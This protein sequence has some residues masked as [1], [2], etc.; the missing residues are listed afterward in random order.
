MAYTVYC[1]TNKINGKK[2]VGLTKLP[3][4]KRWKNGEGYKKQPRFYKDIK[5]YGWEEFT[6]ETLYVGLK[7][8]SRII[9]CCQGKNETSGGYKWRYVE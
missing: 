6:H 7:G 2:Y 3:M 8:S 5:T 4:N 9:Y 1:H